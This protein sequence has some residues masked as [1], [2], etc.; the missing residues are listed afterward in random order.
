VIRSDLHDDPDGPVLVAGAGGFI[1]CRLVPLLRGAGLDVRAAR[2][3]DGDLR[4]I[5]E[6]R[7][8]LEA[9]RPEVIVNLARSTHA[10]DRSHREGHVEIA[11]NLVAAARDAGVRRLIHF[12]SSTEFGR[13]DSPVGDDAPLRPTTPFGVAKARATSLVL[14]ANADGVRTTVL[15]PFSV[16]GPGDL[17][18]HLIPAAIDAAFTG[19]RLPLTSGVRRD[20]V[21]VDDVA[22][23]CALALDGRAD[24]LAVNLASG[25]A[26]SNQR[27]VELV[28]ELTGRQIEV[29]HGAVPPR[30]WD[31]G[32][33]GST[34]RAREILG[35]TAR[36]G[37]S[38][39]LRTTLAANSE[40]EPRARTVTAQ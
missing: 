19:R 28:A 24:G 25:V 2:S 32:I 11:R 18:R 6:T 1:G 31:A 40:T 36:T 38:D 4:R 13:A 10:A 12:G 9:H 39:G 34:E 33:A 23:G 14:G 27:V 37:L 5:D 15:R 8:L 20:W 35:W 29:D 30:P 21:F 22:L 17:R 3:R 26:L 16:Y 7:T